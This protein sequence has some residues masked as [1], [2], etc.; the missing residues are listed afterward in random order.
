M[1]S[2]FA[3]ITFAGA[4]VLCAPAAWGQFSSGSN[5]TDGAFVAAPNQTIT[6]RAG[7]VY[8]YTT[9]RVPPNV[10]LTYLRDSNS[11]DNSPV[12]I[13][14]TGDVSIEGTLTL[15]GFN[16][17]SGNSE[18]GA[19]GAPGGPGGF[20]G[21]NG[22]AFP[23]G[24]QIVGGT[25]GQGP[26]GGNATIP[27]AIAT[28][29]TYGAA[30]SFESLI[31]LFGGS[32]GGG[33]YHCGFNC[34]P[35]SSGAG[36]GGAILIASTTRVSVTGIVR[37]NGGNGGACFSSGTQC[38]GAA[39]SGGA[40]RIVAPQIVG[41]GQLQALGGTG[42]QSI[43]STAGG[44]GKIRL[45]GDTAGFVGITTPT[46]T[47]AT[48]PGPV[49]A[50]GN[51]ALAGVP[52][53]AIASVNSIP[54]PASASGSYG[55]PDITLAPGTTAIPV[56]VNATNTRLQG[57][58]IT[59]RVLPRAPAV[60][61]PFAAGSLTGT[62]ASSSATANVNITA[63]QVVVLQAYAQMTLTGQ[64]ASLFPLIDGEPVERVAIAANLGEASTLSLVTASGKERRVDQLPVE[65]Q[66]RVARVWEVMKDTRTE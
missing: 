3:L 12:V 53:L 20:A 57:T 16:S 15:P 35:G 22:G 18:L 25:P 33:A 48:A 23:G 32:G 56:Q 40:I 59:V 2:R 13:L 58:Q 31:P 64:T 62:F 1:N 63:G 52:T 49:S 51:P 37:A 5:G 36:G 61:T 46:A 65:D 42:F 8:H 54:V 50:S 30:A 45:E 43:A 14:A 6:V 4:L 19:M 39:G 21:G 7:G 66:L 10:T 17:V 24:L 29:G 28:G 34:P 11:T 38:P 44:P 41:T 60:A 27:P 26:G 47:N 9:F 55:S